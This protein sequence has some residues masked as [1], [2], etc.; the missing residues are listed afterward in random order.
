MTTAT[1]TTTTT[2]TTTATATATQ[3]AGTSARTLVACGARELWRARAP[4]LVALAGAPTAALGVRAAS[5]RAAEA[6]GMG[7]SAATLA[8]ARPGWAL[9]GWIVG[10]A[11]AGLLLETSRAV[12]LTAYAGPPRPFADTLVLGLRRA[13]ALIG[14]RAFEL[15]VYSTFA[16]GGL[17]VVARGAH[18]A[19]VAPGPQAL[20][21][22]VCLL[23]LAAL[24]LALFAAGRVAQILVARGLAP[25]AA[26]THGCDLVARRFASLTRLALLGGAATAPLWIGALLLPFALRATL[27]TAA[28]LWLYAAL[29]GLVGRDP[30]LATG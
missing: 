18:G 14:L 28:A 12:A 17:F 13:P 15:I 16:L 20:A 9:V 10:A 2:T 26:L 8:G 1:T 25:A 19:V 23:P 4:T 24:A 30:R 21:V 6:L 7:S 3:S 22:A 11:F 5:V 29:S 27:W